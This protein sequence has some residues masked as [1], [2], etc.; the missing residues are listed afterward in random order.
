[1]SRYKILFVAVIAFAAFF[2]AAQLQATQPEIPEPVKKEA[3]IPEPTKVTPLDPDEIRFNVD[4]RFDESDDYFNQ[5]HVL[6]KPVPGLKKKDHVRFTWPE[7][8]DWK[9]PP[10]GEMHI[11]EEI[12]YKLGEEKDRVQV[13][14]WRLTKEKR[15][16]WKTPGDLQYRVVSPSG[17][18]NVSMRTTDLPGE[19]A[20]A[21]IV[22]PNELN[23]KVI[24]IR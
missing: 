7:E 23:G 21:I 14:L 10:K 1:M 3:N 16:K 18:F 9:K 11:K 13:Q 2:V 4:V 15:P 5:V 19:G 24:Q 22:N 20:F 8:I 12:T 6:V 17:P